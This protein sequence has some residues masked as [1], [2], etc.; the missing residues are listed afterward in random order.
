MSECSYT[1]TEIKA[2]NLVTAEERL[3]VVSNEAAT[4]GGAFNSHAGPF[5]LGGGN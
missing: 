4:G 3:A 1:L 5:S 2:T